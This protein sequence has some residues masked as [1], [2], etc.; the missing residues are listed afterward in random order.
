MFE[1]CSPA[2]LQTFAVA[3]E[4]RKRFNHYYT[5]TEHVLFGLVHDEAGIAGSNLALYGVTA[6]AV[7]AHID[8]L[9]GMSRPQSGGSLTKRA[10]HLMV[11]ARQFALNRPDEYLATEHLLMALCSMSESVGYD[12]LRRIIGAEAIKDLTAQ[13]IVAIS[14]REPLRLSLLHV[15]GVSEDGIS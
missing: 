8:D 11:L 9:I 4:E 1:N 3:G 10:K 6:E 5:G 7:H 2:V 15:G 14:L 12:I 13:I